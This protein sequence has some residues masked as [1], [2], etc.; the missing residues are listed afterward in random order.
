MRLELTLGPQTNQLREHGLP[1]HG[2]PTPTGPFPM[3]TP[4]ALAARTGRFHH[5]RLRPRCCPCT[6][7]KGPLFPRPHGPKRAF[8]GAPFCGSGA[9]FAVRPAASTPGV[10]G[11]GPCSYYCTCSKQTS[12]D[13]T[14]LLQASLKAVISIFYAGLRESGPILGHG[15]EAAPTPRSPSCKHCERANGTA[16]APPWPGS[17]YNAHSTA[18]PEL[19]CLPRPPG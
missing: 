15:T 1:S 3:R 10:S 14:D 6:A 12:L 17:I 5:H 13:P 9:R 16:S 7:A 19:W 8:L 11:C 4:T 2:R 18:A